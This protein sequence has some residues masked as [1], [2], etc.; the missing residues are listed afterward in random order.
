MLTET[1]STLAATTGS[2]IVGAMATDAWTLARARVTRLFARTDAD[3]A[4][5]VEG[6]LDDDESLISHAAAI[7]QD[8]ARAELAPAWR[9]RFARLL[10]EHPDAQDEVRAV[11]AEVAAALPDRQ[12]A[13]I[14]TNVTHGGTTFAVQ[15]G[16]Q[17]IS[18]HDRA[19]DEGPS[20]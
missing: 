19:G 7:E 10:E 11:L 3:R 5:V 2:A 9:R 1:L 4:P 18:Y 12:R 17:Q 16:T 14:Q 20:R 6:Q 15:G 13:W 8:R